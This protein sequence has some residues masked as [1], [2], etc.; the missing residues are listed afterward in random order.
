MINILLL[1]IYFQKNIYTEL[2]TFFALGL[3]LCDRAQCSMMEQYTFSLYVTYS[4]ARCFIKEIY[5]KNR[6]E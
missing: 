4:S 5:I 2:S 6:I 1:F 3:N